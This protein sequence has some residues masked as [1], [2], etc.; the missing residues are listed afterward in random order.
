MPDADEIERGPAAT[1]ADFVKALEKRELARLQVPKIDIFHFKGD[2]VSEWLELLEQVTAEVPEEDKFKFLPRYIW[3]ET[4]PEVMKIAAGAGGDWAKSKA[5]MQRRFKLGDGLLTKTDLKMLQRDEFSTVGAFATAFEKM[6]KKVP[7]LA[8]EEQCATFLEHFKN[9]E[10]SSLTKKVAPGK[11]LTWAAIKEGVI[12]GELDQ[13][14]IFQMRHARKKRKALDASTSE[15][16]NFKRMVEDA[17]AQIDAEKEAK[18]KTMAA[19]QTQGKTKKA[20]VQEE[21][22]EGEEEPEP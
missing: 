7:G 8:E 15:G 22:E 2:R 12:E 4:G 1:P 20:V 13:V 5:E 14:D 21:E 19:P 3:W 17:V 11:K 18:R 16:R 9:W 6:A 10:A